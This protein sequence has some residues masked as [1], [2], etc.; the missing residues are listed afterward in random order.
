MRRYSN[1]SYRQYKNRAR[2][3]HSLQTAVTNPM[4]VNVTTDDVQREAPVSSTRQHGVI[5]NKTEIFT[6]VLSA[7]A[8]LS[9]LRRAPPSCMTPCHI[10]A[11]QV[12]TTQHSCTT[13]KHSCSFQLSE[14]PHAIGTHSTA[15]TERLWMTNDLN[16]IW[17]GGGGH[18]LL[19]HD[20]RQLRVGASN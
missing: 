6:A 9:F 13:A 3:R 15:L 12:L 8:V 2:Q 17:G 10:P 20:D 11:D 7:T 18:C 5:H 14:Q 16:T 19:Q 4:A 1:M